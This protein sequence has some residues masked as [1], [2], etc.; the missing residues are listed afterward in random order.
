MKLSIIVPV[1][2]MAAEGKLEYCMDSLLKQTI[3]D[4]EI[5]AVDDASKDRSPEILREYERRFPGRVKALFHETNKRQGG[6]K[7]TGLAQAAGEWIGFVDSDDWVAPDC[8]EKLLKKGQETGADMVGCNYSLV[9]THTMEPGRVVCNNTADQTGVLD[10][11]KHKKLLLRSGSMVIKIYRN[12]VIKEHGLCFPEG[13]FYED[14]CAGPLWSL[15]FTHFEK[16]EEPLYYYYQHSVSTVHHI[17]E[18][19]CRDRMKAAALFY[20][21]CKKRGM[22]AAYGLEIEYRFTELYYAITLFSYL[23]GV[24]KPRLSFVKELRAG[25]LERFPEF[26]KNPYYRSLT[27]KEE[28]ELIALQGKSAVA[29]FAYYRLKQVIRRLRNYM[30]KKVRNGG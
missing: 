17:T 27:G 29:F 24:R 9:E 3:E 12:S 10:V 16:V 20:D 22:L 1:Y 14:N 7:N 4:Y 8:Y 19:K 6:A 5:I 13:I 15:Y 25:V 28:Q 26:E 2:N 21:E 11:E 30:Q 23:S 18:E